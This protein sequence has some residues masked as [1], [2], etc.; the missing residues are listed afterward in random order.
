MHSVYS[1]TA[2]HLQAELPSA[3]F[4][5]CVDY[6]LKKRYASSRSEAQKM[7]E[8]SLNAWFPFVS[9]EMQMNDPLILGLFGSIFRRSKNLE[10]IDRKFQEGKIP[11]HRQSL[12]LEKRKVFDCSLRALNQIQ[13]NPYFQDH[14]E[15]VRK[16][17]K[18]I[19]A[20]LH[21]SDPLH[22]QTT[23]SPNTLKSASL[24]KNLIGRALRN[25]QYYIA[26]V[27][28]RLFHLFRA[29]ANFFG[30]LLS[31]KK[32]ESLEKG[33]AEVQSA[34]IRSAL[35]LTLSGEKMGCREGGV[36]GTAMALTQEGIEQSL[37]SAL[38]AHQRT[39]PEVKVLAKRI[40]AVR[41]A[42][43]ACQTEPP[44]LQ[45]QLQLRTSVAHLMKT[46]L[47]QRLKN[48][49]IPAINFL[50]FL[51]VKWLAAN[52][53]EA[54]QK[55]GEQCLGSLPKE[56]YTLKE[57]AHLMSRALEE[58]YFNI[59]SKKNRVRWMLAH[60]MK[61]L[62]SYQSIVQPLAYNSSGSNPYFSVH[63]FK[64]DGKERVYYH[65]PSPT[66]EDAVFREGVLPCYK[67]LGR[68]ELRLSFQDMR[69]P[70]EAERIERLM[71]M[72]ENHFPE[73]QHALLGFDT[74]FKWI[75][76]WLKSQG[77]SF[78]LEQFWGPYREF[79]QKGRIHEAKG[80]LESGFDLPDVLL[81]DEKFECAFAKAQHFIEQ[82]SQNNPHWEE[83]MGSEKGRQRAANLVGIITDGFISLEL[84]NGSFDSIPQPSSQSASLDPDLA[85]Y[86]MSGA[87]KQDIDRGVVEGVILYLLFRFQQGSTTLTK[88]E[89]Y[90]IA[91]TVLGRAGIV[92]DRHIMKKRF[93][94]LEDFL[95][96]CSEKV[97]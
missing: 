42:V 67:K 54:L 43:A 51:A 81:S 27:I 50:Q 85:A 75:Q 96:F 47:Y 91:G 13:E 15:A 12:I 57:T 37:Q 30:F 52:G 68:N 24:K 60:P 5:V 48:E 9:K 2:S 16:K 92:D 20:A 82:Q 46:A 22:W 39:S 38:R 10:K 58:K 49:S 61:A 59:D 76:K 72:G 25:T 84:L 28:A 95:C 14:P 3:R 32:T 36:E 8:E 94:F 65:G 87:C 70:W 93:L 41:D 33:L 55:Y 35:L 4:E 21:K 31:P 7:I 80:C 29:A 40:L 69:H 86:R 71:D 83:L 77:N 19:Y 79:V 53:R 34:S 64:K 73:L 18:K 1:I 88:E 6:C 23:L 63:S 17:L 97:D 62:E 78:S 90:E 89:V 56:T 26:T 44:S 74:K 11:S 66:K 45:R